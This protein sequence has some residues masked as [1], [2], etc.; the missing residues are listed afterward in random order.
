MEKLVDLSINGIASSL[1]LTFRNTQINAVILN[2]IID[3][4]LNDIEIGKKEQLSSSSER[5]YQESE[6]SKKQFELSKFLN[7][8]NG[9]DQQIK[10]SVEKI[11]LEVI[12]RLQGKQIV[13]TTPRKQFSDLTAQQIAFLFDPL[14]EINCINDRKTELGD[15]LSILF[16]ISSDNIRTRLSNSDNMD[17]NDFNKCVAFMEIWMERLK[18]K[19]IMFEK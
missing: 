17:L 6:L 8:N 3:Q 4:I 7:A 16:G 19:R 5:L 10:D 12:S 18:N 13:V 14:R 15:G 11:F 2:Q 9:I 1:Q